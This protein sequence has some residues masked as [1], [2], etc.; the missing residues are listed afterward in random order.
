MTSLSIRR[1]CGG[2]SAVAL[3]SKAPSSEPVRLSALHVWVHAR[4]CGVAP[5]SPHARAPGALQRG[6]AAPQLR[7]CMRMCEPCAQVRE[8]T[9]LYLAGQIIGTTGYEEAASL[10]TIA[11]AN[12]ALACAERPPL[13]IGRKGRARAHMC[14]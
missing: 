12:A 5:Q 7:T 1:L 2:A 14:T 4:T 6:D 3:S 13:I 8:C 9:G 10:G 11:G